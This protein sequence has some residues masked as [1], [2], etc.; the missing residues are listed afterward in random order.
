MSKSREL[1]NNVYCK[2]LVLLDLV[3]LLL[4]AKGD[5]MIQGSLE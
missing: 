3:D 1:E 2:Q 5:L 4:H